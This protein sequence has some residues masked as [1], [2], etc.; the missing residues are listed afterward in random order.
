MLS[1]SIVRE[2]SA[3]LANIKSGSLF[4]VKEHELEESRKTI[5]DFN[6]CYSKKGIRLAEL[7][8]REN[9]SLL[10]MYR[11]K[12]LSEDLRNSKAAKLLRELGYS[13]EG[14][15]ELIEELK[16]RFES[17]NSF[18][19]EV[20]LFLSYPPEDV[21]AFIEHREVGLKLTGTWKAYSEAEE[22]ERCFRKYRICRD[23]YVR[24]YRKGVSLSRL[25]VAAL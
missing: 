7:L 21:R 5:E 24:Q 8:R 1:E 13:G 11:I 9:Y 6:R 23:A 15:E 16:Y 2:C 18:P 22:A 10:Y 17:S 12:K 20:G 3:T 19:H 4:K 25:I 14:A